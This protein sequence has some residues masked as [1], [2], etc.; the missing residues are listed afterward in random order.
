[1]RSTAEKSAVDDEGMF[2][3]RLVIR[4]D[5]GV[6][7]DGRARRLGDA[8]QASAQ[9]QQ[10][11]ACG[12]PM[13]KGGNAGGPRAAP[14]A[15]S[16]FV[17]VNRLTRPRSFADL[18][19]NAPL[20]K[21]RLQQAFERIA[22]DRRADQRRRFAMAASE[23]RSGC[24]EGDLRIRR[25]EII[26]SQSLWAPNSSPPVEVSRHNGLCRRARYE[27]PAASHE[28]ARSTFPQARRKD[29]SNERV[30]PVRDPALTR[31]AISHA[32]LRVERSA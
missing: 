24:D 7:S 25:R 22:A 28:A 26:G 17:A 1:M 29:A 32:S 21:S 14:F 8:G 16:N 10:L 27:P 12:T 9:S 31:V 4:R 30:C 3:F 13:S 23:R 18:W 6:S 2:R 19:T 15:Q 20:R 11:S 5:A